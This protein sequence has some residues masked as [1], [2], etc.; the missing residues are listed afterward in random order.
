M[1]SKESI[2]AVDS[3]DEASYIL[4]AANTVH[5]DKTPGESPVAFESIRMSGLPEEIYADFS[6]TPSLFHGRDHIDIF[7]S[8]RS[9]TGLAEKVWKQLI[10]PALAWYGLK[11][12][13]NYGVHLTTS[14]T[15][16]SELTQELVLLRA[17][18][19][20]SQT[21]VLLSGDG[22]MVDMVNALVAGP[23]SERYVKPQIA[24]LPFGTGNALANSSGITGSNAFGLRSLLNGQPKEVPVFRATFSVGARLLTNE[25]REERQLE[26]GVDG[27][28]VAHGAVVCSWGLHATLVADSDT[29]EYRKFGAERFK[30]AGKEALY[31]SD[32]SLPHA[33]KGQVSILKAG[34]ADWET[35]DRKEHGY[36]LA[37]LTSHLEAGFR[38]SPSSKPLD[39]KLRL[40]DFGRLSGDEAMGMMTEAYQDGQHVYDEKVGYEDIEGLKIE[41]AEDD[42]RWRRVCIDGKIIRVDEGGWVEV[43]MAA[44]GVVDLLV[45]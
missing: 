34:A 42:G 6:S 20:E 9:G 37:T 26:G 31:P 23:R 36:V 4:Y 27:Q 16:I 44:E 43:K 28:P 13:E 41:F 32:G 24:L 11:V 5:G 19:G 15:T 3:R 22:G 39:E 12:H 33:Y 7:I 29:T 30:M 45:R 10:K 17:N 35:L 25:G 40:V 1:T 14:E 8:T 38:I 18:K 2:I 21:I